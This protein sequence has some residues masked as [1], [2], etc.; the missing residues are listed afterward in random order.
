MAYFCTFNYN[1][2]VWIG[3]KSPLFTRSYSAI[4]R[5]PHVHVNILIFLTVNL[6]KPHQWQAWTILHVLQATLWPLA[7][8]KFLQSVF[9]SCFH[10]WSSCIWAATGFITHKQ[11][12]SIILLFDNFLINHAMCSTTTVHT[13]LATS[14]RSLLHINRF[15]IQILLLTIYLNSGNIYS[16]EFHTFFIN[17]STCL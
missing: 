1:R 16:C 5:Q 7:C 17:Q 9:F 6:H 14:I 4:H 12:M 10:F 8:I 15:V 2:L 13:P 11:F 3:Y